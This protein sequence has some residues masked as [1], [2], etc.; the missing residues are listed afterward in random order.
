[1]AATMETGAVNMINRVIPHVAVDM[2][3]YSSCDTQTF[4]EETCPPLC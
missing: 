2:V 3:S 4:S 1:M